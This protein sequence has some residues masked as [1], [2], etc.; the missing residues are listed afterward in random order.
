VLKDRASSH[1]VSQP[2]PV[3]DPRTQLVWVIQTLNATDPKCLFLSLLA[4]LNGPP[5]FY[6]SEK[7]FILQRNVPFDAKHINLLPALS[8]ASRSAF[9]WSAHFN[10]VH[11]GCRALYTKLPADHA[12]QKATC[13]QQRKRA[14]VSV[15]QSGLL[16]LAQ[17]E[18]TALAKRVDYHTLDRQK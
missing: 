2:L 14:P 13:T 15:E 5:K 18:T 6:T 4:L 16:Q 7:V 3:E 8:L 11:C 9:R 10:P 17:N 12:G 1:F